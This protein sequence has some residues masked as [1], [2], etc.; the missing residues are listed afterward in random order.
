MDSG[1]MCMD[2]A[3]EYLSLKKSYLYLQVE[4]REIPHYRFG[5]LIKFKQADLDAWM[6]GFRVPLDESKEGS[7]KAPRGPRKHRV[8]LNAIVKK[9][10]AEV[11][12]SVYTDGHEESDRF[13]GLR[14]EASHGAL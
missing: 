4:R 13:K 9:A 12:G 5:R 14:K 8:N 10:I 7:G 2:E 1:Y 11:K 3:A 6:A